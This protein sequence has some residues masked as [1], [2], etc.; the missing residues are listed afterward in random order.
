LKFSSGK[1]RPNID[2]PPVPLK[3]VKSPPCAINL[4]MI[5]W[6]NEFLYPNPFS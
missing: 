5:R 6:N 4:G 1:V 3:F 2:F